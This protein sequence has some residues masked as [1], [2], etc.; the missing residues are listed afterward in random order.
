MKHAMHYSI[1]LLLFFTN[2]TMADFD[3]GMNYYNNKNYEKAFQE[4][5]ESAQNGDHDAQFNLGVMYLKGE[6]TTK[7]LPLA[8]AWM[9]LAT[10]STSYATKG[11]EKKIYTKIN[12]S[13]KNKADETYLSLYSEYSDAKVLEKLQPNLLPV[14]NKKIHRIIRQRTTEY[15]AGARH[16]L[17]SGF[18]DVIFS[19][20]KDGTTKDQVIFSASDEIFIK[21]TL[22]S[23]RGMLFEPTT[24]DGKAVVTNG[25]RYR[26]IFKIANDDSFDKNKIKK[27]MAEMGSKASS[28]DSKAQFNYAYFLEVVPSLSKEVEFDN[29]N[30][31]YLTAAKNGSSSAAY[32]L[33]R[34][35]INGDMCTADPIKGS[36]WLI[37][38][39]QSNLTDAQYLL[40]IESFSGAIIPKNEEKGLFWLKQAA[41]DNNI[42]KIKLAWILVTHPNA[43]Y[44]DSDLAT[45]YF[46]KVHKNHT[47][48][49]TYLQ[50]AAA[51]AAEKGD[52]KNAIKWQQKAI[53]DAKKLDLPLGTVDAQLTSYQN[54]KPWREEP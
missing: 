37:K 4:F 53:K 24:I 5:S 26:F 2:Q 34:N 42:A 44:R 8:Y 7:N 1:I 51:I 16:F 25:V 45:E 3:L 6:F 54:N 30:T 23:L 39:S 49:Q 17:L 36:R 32:F 14:S 11:T 35:L 27:H 21:P 50:T 28:G 18:V 19:I 43:V 38:A 41:Q 47:D 9:K 10:Q 20:G 48:Q 52:F 12:A 40:A 46:M 31:W 29:P 13:E 15:P 22:R 33:G